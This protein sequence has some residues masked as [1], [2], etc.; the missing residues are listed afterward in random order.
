[1]DSNL[2]EDLIKFKL[3]SIQETIRKILDKWHESNIDDFLN[4]AKIGE[5]PDAELDAITIKQL[6]KD[7]DKLE[8]L[9]KQ[10]KVGNSYL[11]DI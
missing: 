4:K 11:G 6:V 10:I 9:L 7:L 3:K 2:A 1:M 5:L 8:N